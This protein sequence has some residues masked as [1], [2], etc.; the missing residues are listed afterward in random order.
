MLV[1]C[2]LLDTPLLQPVDHWV[3]LILSE[4]QIAHDQRLILPRLLEG[5]V[6][7][8]RK[9]RLYVNALGGDAEVAAR[10]VDAVDVAFHPLALFAHRLPDRVPVNRTSLF[11]LCLSTTPTAR[12]Q[13]HN[14]NKT[15]HGYKAC[16]DRV[17]SIQ[18]LHG[19]SPLN[20]PI[21]HCG[22][23]VPPVQVAPRSG[24]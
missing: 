21:N 18:D 24:A 20:K 3:V 22:S 17:S 2:R 23:P 7:A 16:S 12:T 1:D 10:Q 4:H 13:A 11:I 5:R 15:S 9:P 6:R 19:G 14:S 8:K